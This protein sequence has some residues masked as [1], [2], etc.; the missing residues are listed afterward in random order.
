MGAGSAVISLPS[1]A[2]LQI[3]NTCSIKLKAHNIRHIRITPW[4]IVYGDSWMFTRSFVNNLAQIG[5]QMARMIT[6][7]QK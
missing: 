7:I 2:G 4:I 6:D 3:G 1:H 5:G